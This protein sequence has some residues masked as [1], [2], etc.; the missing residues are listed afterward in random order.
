MERIE[1]KNRVNFWDA[2]YSRIHSFDSLSLHWK[3]VQF[4]YESFMRSSDEELIKHNCFLWPWI[5][6]AED[7]Q[8]QRR[9]RNSD[10]AQCEKNNQMQKKISSVFFYTKVDWNKQKTTRR[11]KGKKMMNETGKMVHM[12]N[13]LLATSTCYCEIMSVHAQDIFSQLKCATPETHGI[14]IHSTQ[15]PGN[16]KI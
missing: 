2:K 10:R 9:R 3:C 16:L 11:N 15:W 13:W 6:S 5:R 8:K 1:E 7:A 14:V 4:L 12:K